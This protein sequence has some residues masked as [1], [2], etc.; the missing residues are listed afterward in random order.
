MKPGEEEFESSEND[1]AALEPK[2]GLFRHDSDIWKIHKAK[3][4][5]KDSVVKPKTRKNGKKLIFEF[6]R[7]IFFCC[8]R[9]PLKK[10]LNQKSGIMRLQNPFFET[11]LTVLKRKKFELETLQ[12]KP[13]NESRKTLVIEPFYLLFYINPEPKIEKIS[14][15]TRGQASIRHNSWAR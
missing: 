11:K 1:R 13:A 5:K 8:V 7:G 3:I 4:E 6:F 2:M 14:V 9:N 10:P 15:S 12:P